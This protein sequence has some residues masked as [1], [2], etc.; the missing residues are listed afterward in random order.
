MAASLHN[1]RTLAGFSMHLISWMARSSLIRSVSVWVG[2]S[3]AVCS[4]SVASYSR[5]ASVCSPSCISRVARLLLFRSVY[6][7]VC[8][9]EMCRRLPGNHLVVEPPCLRPLLHFIQRACQVALYRP[10]VPTGRYSDVRSCDWI[11]QFS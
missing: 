5:R 10:G 3:S 1:G 11:S 9:P 7:L 4:A 6:N 8:W 2:P